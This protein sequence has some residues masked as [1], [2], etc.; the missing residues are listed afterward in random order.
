MMMMEVTLLQ[1]YFSR[2]QDTLLQCRNWL[3]VGLMIISCVQL[4]RTMRFRCGNFP[5]LFILPTV[6]QN[7][8][9]FTRR[10]RMTSHH[11][12]APE[13]LTIDGLCMCQCVPNQND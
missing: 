6:M 12:N 13:A 3:G 1:S 8:R 10:R 11:V 9:T 5:L 2:T 7:L 4:T